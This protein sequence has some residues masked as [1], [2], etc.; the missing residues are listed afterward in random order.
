LENKINETFHPI[1]SN[2][3]AEESFLMQSTYTHTFYSKKVPSNIRKDYEEGKYCHLRNTEYIE[4]IGEY[5]KKKI[6]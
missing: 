3:E 1:I 2:E 4:I 6:I 5:F